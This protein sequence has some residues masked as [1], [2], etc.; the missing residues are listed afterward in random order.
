MQI[1]PFVY[2]VNETLQYTGCMLHF[3][4][5]PSQFMQKILIFI[6][7]TIYF[8]SSLYFL[9]LSRHLRSHLHYSYQL[10]VYKYS[11]VL[12]YG[13]SIYG[14]FFIPCT[15]SVLISHFAVVIL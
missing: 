1:N 13:C 5:S 14:T 15:M 12:M 2:V 8:L 6:F 9:M 10:F 11:L 7:F 3:N 4:I